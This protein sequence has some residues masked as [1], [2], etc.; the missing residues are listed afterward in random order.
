MTVLRTLIFI[1][2]CG[3]SSSG[4]FANIIDDSQN[5]TAKIAATLTDLT[6]GWHCEADPE[7]VAFALSDTFHAEL[8][9]ASHETKAPHADSPFVLVASGLWQSLWSDDRVIYEVISE[10]AFRLIAESSHPEEEAT[11]LVCT[12]QP[13]TDL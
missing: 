1:V 9:P 2:F 10:T 6:G 12:K 3:L 4:A 7:A 11:M 8:S 5:F 13:V